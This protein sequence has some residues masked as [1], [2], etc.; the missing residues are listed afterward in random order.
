MTAVR[1]RVDTI[2]LGPFGINPDEDGFG[3]HTDTVQLYPPCVRNV[4]P[5]QWVRSA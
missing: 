5:V 1:M 3:A 2:F 4:C